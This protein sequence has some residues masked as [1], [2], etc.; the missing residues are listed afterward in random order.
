MIVNRRRFLQASSSAAAAAFFLGNLDAWGAA[1]GNEFRA[2]RRNVGLFHGRGGTIGWLAGPDALLV[3]DSQYP[4]QA[5]DFLSRWEQRGERS[6][7]VLINTHHHMDHTGG[8][9]E[10]RPKVKQ[11]V[12]Q[13]NVPR[14]QREA[15][16][17]LDREVELTF[18]D[19]TF[20]REWKTE[21]GDEIVTAVHYGAAHTGGD[22]VIHFEKANIVHMGDLTW[23]GWH[24]FTDRRGGAS[25]K[26]W[27]DVLETVL[28]RHD[29][30]TLFVF[31][32][33]SEGREV[34]GDRSLVARQRDYFTAV[35]ELTRTGIREGKT[36]TEIAGEGILEGFEELGSPG[37]RLSLAYNVD[38][39][40]Q[41]LT[42]E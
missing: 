15:A 10:F 6:I 16:K 42:E 32:H 26:G 23:N 31:G 35:L 3:V 14:L 30:E 19:T 5:A 7:D 34:T 29:P 17:M 13:E 4:E 22:S 39:A 36:A 40:Y 8:N 25:M 37:K 33:A 18:P 2:L 11:I 20:A 12:A 28:E 1:T 27:V 21:A 24:P 9:G 41:E 38:V